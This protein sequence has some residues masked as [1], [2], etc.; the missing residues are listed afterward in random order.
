M[1]SNDLH[2]G[3]HLL[4]TNDLGQTD[5]IVIPAFLNTQQ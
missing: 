2:L 1:H 3:V 5:E 4:I